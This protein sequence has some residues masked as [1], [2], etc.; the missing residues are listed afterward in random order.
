MTGWNSI[1]TSKTAD[2]AQTDMNTVSEVQ[3]FVDEPPELG[4]N[5]LLAGGRIGR[6]AALGR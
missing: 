2:T 3:R 5:R 4:L 1:P 6:P